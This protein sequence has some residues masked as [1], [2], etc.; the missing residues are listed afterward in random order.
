MASSGV[1]EHKMGTH[2]MVFSDGHSSKQ[3]LGLCDATEI[4]P[5][6]S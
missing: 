6:G 3:Q 2:S 5:L 1:T 4:N